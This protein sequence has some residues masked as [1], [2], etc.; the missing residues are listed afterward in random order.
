MS[1]T[2]RGSTNCR[3]SDA[4]KGGTRNRKF[5]L[6]SRP[7]EA[8]EGGSGNDPLWIDD[9]YLED[10]NGQNLANPVPEP[11]SL[12]GLASFALVLVCYLRVRRRRTCASAG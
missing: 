6:H 2:A 4:R 11:Q 5:W 1:A 8:A 10:S 7:G 3:S 12:A 9:I